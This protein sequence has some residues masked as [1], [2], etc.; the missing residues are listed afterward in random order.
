[1]F[2]A[3]SV[4]M[5]GRTVSRNRCDVV[6]IDPSCTTYTRAFSIVDY[7]AVNTPF[8][9]LY[10]DEVYVTY[11]TGRRRLI[12]KFGTSEIVF[13]KLR[14]EFFVATRSTEP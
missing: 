5:G 7:D 1:M 12:P 11:S 10:N 8:M 13:S 6:R 14:R 4:Q 3:P 9:C 2:T